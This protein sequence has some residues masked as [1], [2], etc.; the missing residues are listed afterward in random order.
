MLLLVHRVAR[1]PIHRRVEVGLS[2]VKVLIAL[3]HLLSLLLLHEKFKHA[4][5]VF[6]HGSHGGHLLLEVP[7]VHVKH[8]AVVTRGLLLR[9][10]GCGRG[11][12]LLDRVEF[13]YTL[14]ALHG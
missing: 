11:C 8:A 13:A 4:E 6:L 5:V 9:L 14:L 3:A 12:R 10:L 1:V 7:L 2:R